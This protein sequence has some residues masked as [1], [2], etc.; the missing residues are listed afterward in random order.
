MTK[1]EKFIN[2]NCT[3]VKGVIN[4]IYDKITGED[5]HYIDYQPYKNIVNKIMVNTQLY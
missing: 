3:A 1:Y 2:E 4:E 5:S